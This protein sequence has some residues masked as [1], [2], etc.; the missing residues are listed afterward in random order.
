MSNHV[1]YP[2]FRT[3]DRDLALRVARRMV[4]FGALPDSEVS[5][6]IG[7][8]STT[9][10]AGRLRDVLPDAWF[11]CW[12][13]DVPAAPPPGIPDLT[14]SVPARELPADLADAHAYLP[15]SVSMLDQPPGSIEEHF[16]SVAGPHP[17]EIRWSSLTWPEAPEHGLY[18]EGTHAMVTLLL[19]SDSLELDVRADTHLVLVHVRHRTGDDY[20]V[21]FAQ[22][23]AEQIG[24]QVIGAP[25]RP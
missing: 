9:A 12:N 22:W 3:P 11:T 8:V 23:L 15:L 10:E 5:V 13:T 18:G 24:Q 25:Q 17:A 7:G 16:A 19:N 1:A 20:E 2:V 6:E 21:R 4:A 14:L